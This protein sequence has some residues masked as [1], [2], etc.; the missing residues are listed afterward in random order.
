VGESKIDVASSPS[1]QKVCAELNDQMKGLIPI[2]DIVIGKR[3]RKDLGDL[4]NLKRSLEEVGLIQPVVVNKV[5]GRHHLIAGRRR[6]EAARQLGWEKV[7]CH[8]TTSFSDAAR[9]LKAER[10][11]NLHRKDM[12]PSE[13]VALGKR[14]EALERPAA[15]D[16]Q[17]EHGGTAP[18]RE[19]NTAGKFPEVLPGRTRDKVAETMGVSGR[20]YEKMVEVTEAAEKNPERFGDLR[21]QM[22]QTGK[23]DAAFKEM[24]RRQG[25]AG[26]GRRHE[27]RGGVVE[28]ARRREAADAAADYRRHADLVIRMVEEDFDAGGAVAAMG[29]DLAGRYEAAL[30]SLA[31][32]LDD[33]RQARRRL[34]GG[35]QP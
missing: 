28:Q 9:A 1:V 18:G 8:V 4:T 27:P 26:G 19:A 34:A 20:T 10:D 32:R 23:V 5:K 31:G 7:Q 6:L 17:R 11:E 13:M 22:D 14:L 30:A 35:G 33:V 24:T 2:A 12:T 3:I 16:R 21:E 29:A 15:K 25:R